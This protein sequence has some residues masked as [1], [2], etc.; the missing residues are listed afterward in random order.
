MTPEG[1]FRIVVLGIDPQLAGRIRQALPGVV[2]VLDLPASGSALA[3]IPDEE[4]PDL[5]IVDLDRVD[6]AALVGWASSGEFGQGRPSI[7]GLTHR[8]DAPGKLAALRL[9]VD[10][11]LDVPFTPDELLIRA[12]VLSR[13]ASAPVPPRSP[14]DLELDPL[15]RRVRVGGHE[16]ALTGVEWSLLYLLIARVGEIV[17]RDEI[18]DALWSVD[19]APDSNVIER[20]VRSLRH[21]LHDDWHR[22]RYIETVHGRGYRLLPDSVQRWRGA[23]RDGETGT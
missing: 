10:D 5:V 9:G 4:W 1:P 20:H 6:L 11:V 23:G 18:L 22:P 8:R 16:V 13:R 3:P 17:T 7:L 2:T 12:V 19:F 14:A 15:H 21:K